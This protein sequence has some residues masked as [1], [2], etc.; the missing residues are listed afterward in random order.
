MVEDAIYW[1]ANVS[2]LYGGYT[3][4]KYRSAFWACNKPFKKMR[5][6]GF[7]SNALVF[8]ALTTNLKCKNVQYI[9]YIYIYI[10][11]RHILSIV[12]F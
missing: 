12:N 4:A 1:K 7:I 3:E 2:Y 11:A 5:N 6:V 10:Y 9:R 8:K